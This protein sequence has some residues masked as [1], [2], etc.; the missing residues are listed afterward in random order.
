MRAAKREL[1]EEL[2]IT[3]KEFTK[4]GKIGI[5]FSIIEGETTQYIARKLTFGKT[6]RDGAEEM[7]SVKISLREAAEKVFTG[8]INHAPSCV[9]IL[10]AWELSEK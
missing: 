2:G 7:K 1:K 5:D 6:D 8:E 10:K 4:V 9:L 3:A